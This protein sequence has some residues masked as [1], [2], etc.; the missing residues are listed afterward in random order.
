M[1]SP[2][3]KSNFKKKYNNYKKLLQ[4]GKSNDINESDTVAI[5]ASMLVDLFGYEWLEDIT[6]ENAI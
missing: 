5:I 1:N 3:F 2:K 6:S 4:K